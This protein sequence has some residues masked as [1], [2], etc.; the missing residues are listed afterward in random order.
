M[1][2]KPPITGANCVTSRPFHAE[3]TTPLYY[4]RSSMAL[5]YD[6]SGTRLALRTSHSIVPLKRSSSATERSHIRLHAH[7]GI[8]RTPPDVPV[9]AVRDRHVEYF[10]RHR[11]RIASPTANTVI[12]HRLALHYVHDFLIIKANSSVTF[13]HLA[14]P[15]W[16]CTAKDICRPRTPLRLATQRF[17]AFA[18]RFQACP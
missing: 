12:S 1:A 7:P 14:P 15:T 17:R 11:H 5:I 9:H 2:T 16:Y 13:A 10:M 4:P 18:S 6:L 3:H 8:R